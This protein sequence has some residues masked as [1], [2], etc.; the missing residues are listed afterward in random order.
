M[1]S[2]RPTRSFKN[3]PRNFYDFQLFNRNKTVDSQL[4]LTQRKIMRYQPT[5]AIVGIILALTIGIHTAETNSNPTT[6]TANV[7]GIANPWLAGAPDGTIAGG[8][9]DV[10]P[11]QSPLEVTGIS[12]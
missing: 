9:Y 3:G 6:I 10:A 12:A 1:T 11:N 7:P 2:G 4:E 5:N 8:N